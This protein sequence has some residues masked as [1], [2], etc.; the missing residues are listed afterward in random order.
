M[1]DPGSKKLNP[2]GNPKRDSQTLRRF[3]VYWPSKRLRSDM[4]RNKVD[5]F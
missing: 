5:R 3:T 1:Y 4:L 2:E